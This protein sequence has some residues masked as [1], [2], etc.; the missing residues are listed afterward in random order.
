MRVEREAIIAMAKT[1]ADRKRNKPEEKTEGNDKTKIS[2]IEEISYIGAVREGNQ[3]NRVLVQVKIGSKLVAI[4]FD[5]GNPYSIISYELMRSL[6]IS[7]GF[8]PSRARFFLYDEK[9]EIETLG[10]IEVNV[11]F[12]GQTVRAPLHVVKGNYAPL[13][14]RDWYALFKIDY[15]KIFAEFVNQSENVAKIGAITES[16]KS[17]VQEFADIFSDVIG[18]LT[19]GVAK[20]RV[21]SDAKPIFLKA[22]PVP[23]VLVD[24]VEH[25]IDRLVQL[26]VLVPTTHAA[27]ATPVVPVVKHD[28]SVRLCG[29][30]KVTVNRCIDV[31]EYPIPDV[32][33]ILAR[34]GSAIIHSKFD[35]TEAYMQIPVDE[36]TSKLLT[37]N[38]SK[39]LFRVTRLMY[40]VA[41]APA[42]FQ[43]FMEMIFGNI[44]GL[45]AFFDDFRLSSE[46]IDEHVAGM[47]EFFK[48]CHENGRRLKLNKCQIML[49][50]IDYLGYQIGENGLEKIKEKV[51]AI[52]DAER[53]TNVTQVKSFIGLVNY[54]ARFF[55]NLSSILD[56][57]NALLRNGVKF[58]WSDECDT[59]FESVKKE[60][61]SPRIL[62]L[63]DKTKPLVLATDASGVGIVAV[64]SHRDPDGNDRPIAFASRSLT[65]AERNYAQIDREAL[66]IYWGCK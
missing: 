27:W 8:L 60:I 23:F 21:K 35:I 57:L 18:K 22:R 19:N 20:I 61:V 52:T 48:R 47:R 55:P 39:G 15:N 46:S 34:V 36:Q 56:P 63:Y 29:D 10:K 42:I 65:K 24:R 54:Y 16:A 6:G 62:A 13:F 43:R 28:G 31:D 9:T 37:I 64:I 32:D 53:P 4:E 41:S 44:K 25:E 5:S 17:C 12:H 1:N 33:A 7:E 26:G 14:G 11:E 66:V 49:P 38:T 45:Q 30:Y 58:E 50:S 3:D 59:A 2:K 51:K 40:G